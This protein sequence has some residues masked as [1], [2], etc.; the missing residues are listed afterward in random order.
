MKEQ[1]LRGGRK[2]EEEKKT[3]F[4]SRIQNDCQSHS[5]QER[6]KESRVGQWAGD[7]RRREIKWGQVKGGQNT[8]F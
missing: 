1:T 4:L 2:T 3:H 6:K 7:D 5:G 8:V